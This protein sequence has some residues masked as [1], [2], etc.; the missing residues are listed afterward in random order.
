MG[1]CL[2]GGVTEPA[3]MPLVGLEWVKC[4][5]SSAVFCGHLTTLSGMHCGKCV[6]RPVCSGA[7]WNC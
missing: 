7:V 5:R 1:G 3:G 4:R 6:R 2:R